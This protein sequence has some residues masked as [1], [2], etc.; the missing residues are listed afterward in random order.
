[1]FV[2]TATP[3]PRVEDPLQ[4]TAVFFSR[5]TH[6]E[7]LAA[8][9][10]RGVLVLA[11]VIVA[12]VLLR[13]GRRVLTKVGQTR[14]IPDAVLAPFRI[15]LRYLLIVLVVIL[16]L[17]FMGVE[18]A[19]IWA[20]LSTLLALVAIGF[21]A[22]WSTLSNVLCSLLL[23]IFKPFRIGDTIEIVEPTGDTKGIRGRVVDLSLMFTVIRADGNQDVF[24]VPNNTFFQKTIRR[25]AGRATVSI[26]DHVQQHGL[27]GLNPDANREP[28][29]SPAT[30]PAT[31][32]ATT[33]ASPA[34]QG[35]SPA[36]Y[37]P[38]RSMPR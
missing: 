22:V 2:M 27:T 36:E 14:R 16:S 10:V 31:T 20:V 25:T 9:A 1:M 37:D 26:E 19:T 38:G 23:M 7:F 3:S 5:F 21:V 32:P 11:T 35:T 34:R 12:M 33:P 13:V 17:Q 4:E 28:A 29:A 8:V 30:P 18:M 6:P 24:E 15:G